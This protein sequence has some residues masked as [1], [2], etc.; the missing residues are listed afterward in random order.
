MERTYGGELA[1]ED[2]PDT[3]RHQLLA[4]ECVILDVPT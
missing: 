3:N 2:S 4:G 1:P